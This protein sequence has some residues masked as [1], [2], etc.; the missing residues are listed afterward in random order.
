MAKIDTNKIR[1]KA[2][3]ALVACL[4]GFLI[5]L[6]GSLIDILKD[7]QHIP[8]ENVAGSVTAA[9]TYTYRALKHYV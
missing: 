9:A 4:V 7:M 2:V 8:I 3:D 6:F 5:T 1:E